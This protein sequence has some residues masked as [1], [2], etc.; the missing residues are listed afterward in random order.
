MPREI[1]TIQLGQCGNQ[2]EYTSLHGLICVADMSGG[3]RGIALGTCA[4]F[5]NALVTNLYCYTQLEWSSGSS[6]APSMVSVQVCE[7]II[8]LHMFFSIICSCIIACHCTIIIMNHY[9]GSSGRF[10]H[11]SNGQ[12]GCLLLS[13]VYTYMYIL[14]TVQMYCMHVHVHVS[15]AS[16]VHGH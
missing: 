3:V 1:I 4:L 10:R 5:F 9:R 7:V 8:R 15:I 14:Y 2:S 12:K 13:G 6:C 11:S 16:T